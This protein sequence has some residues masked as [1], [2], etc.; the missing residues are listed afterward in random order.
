MIEY[1]ALEKMANMSGIFDKTEV[2]G[3]FTRLVNRSE[4]DHLT[5][6]RYMYHGLTKVDQTHSGLMSHDY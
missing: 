5:V 2:R 4:F 3:K 6:C 1:T